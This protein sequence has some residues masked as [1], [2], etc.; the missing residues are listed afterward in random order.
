MKITFIGTG[1]GYPDVGRQCSSTMLEIGGYYYFIDA[2]A[3][4]AQYI[5]D[6]G[7]DRSKIRAL[8][9]THRHGDHFWGCFRL[10]SCISEFTLEWGNTQLDVVL[11]EARAI[12]MCHTLLLGDSTLINYDRLHFYDL[13]TKPYYEDENIKLT[14]VPTEH[15]NGRLKA[16]AFIVEAEGKKLLFT[17]DMHARLHD[18]PEA[19]LGDEQFDF[20]LCEYAHSRAEFM[21]PMLPRIN[22]KKLYFNHLGVGKEARIAEIEAWDKQY[23]ATEMRA[24]VTDG[25]QIEL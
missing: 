8:F 22:T 3:D 21:E 11:P 19:A 23:P 15:T 5:V 6:N 12:H 10:L 14:A 16:W 9:V 17:G 18:F 2:G 20:I 25:E 24:V 4:I 7:I 13:N 1:H